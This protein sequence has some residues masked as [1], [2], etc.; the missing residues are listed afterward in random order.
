[1]D[2]KWERWIN[3]IREF[4]SGE[5]RLLNAHFSP[6][7]EEATSEEEAYWLSDFASDESHEIEQI[8]DLMCG[9]LVVGL[10]SRIEYYL[11]HTLSIITAEG[12]AQTVNISKIT[13]EYKSHGK[14]IRLLNSVNIANGIRLSC[15]AFKHNAGRYNKVE[16][17][18]EKFDPEVF[19]LF[20]INEED[21]NSEKKTIE[22]RY[23]N[24]D[25]PGLFAGTKAFI[26]DLLRY[27]D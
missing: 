9:S 10:W 18:I 15:N 25:Y 19:P 23:G 14:D 11:K 12:I 3:A 24:F 13:K 16:E 21:I 8:H 26:E 7:I 22:L 2:C 5:E 20:S 17:P 27:L 1:M 6:R 4:K